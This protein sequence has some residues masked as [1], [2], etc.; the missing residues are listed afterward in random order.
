M[1]VFVTM[2]LSLLVATAVIDLSI[3]E[4]SAAASIRVAKKG[5]RIIYRVGEKLGI[6]SKHTEIIDLRKRT[7]QEF[8]RLD[9]YES[10]PRVLIKG[11]EDYV[12]YPQSLSNKA[13]KDLQDSLNYITKRR[14]E[15]I[16]EDLDQDVTELRAWRK[17]F[18][19]SD[20]SRIA[21]SSRLNEDLSE[22]T[23][24]EGELLFAINSH[25]T[26][27]RLAATSS[28]TGASTISEVK[29]HLYKIAA[30]SDTNP[31]AY[32]EVSF[33]DDRGKIKQW[34]LSSSSSAHDVGEIA[35]HYSLYLMADF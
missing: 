17:P 22:I 19:L 8:G 30:L 34:L 28:S 15:M 32:L 21:S 23:E 25:D 9:S 20:D 12:M 6:V 11:N 14:Q 10:V 35:R 5:G 33:I 3:A 1:K 26:A 4:A 2:M 27:A 7:P 16:E 24:A 31:R 29:R 13:S 18:G